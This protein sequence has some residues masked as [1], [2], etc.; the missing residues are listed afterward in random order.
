MDDAVVAVEDDSTR[1]VLMSRIT[2][3]LSEF[4]SA[5]RSAR[6][7]N[8]RADTPGLTKTRRVDEAVS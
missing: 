8:L 7:E 1:P 4:A 3:S 5:S 6:G 2:M